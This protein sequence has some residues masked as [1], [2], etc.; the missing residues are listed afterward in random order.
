MRER[1]EAKKLGLKTYSTGKA[2]KHGH[3]AARNTITGKCSECRFPSSLKHREYNARWRSKYP[4]R[5]QE[6]K[7][8]FRYGVELSQIR[9]KP[10]CCEV[11]GSSHKKIV[12]DHCHTTGAFRGWLCDPCN[13]VL[14]LVKDNP[15]TL[16]AL[17]GH[18]RRPQLANVI[19]LLK[20]QNNAISKRQVR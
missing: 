18:L 1:A 7:Y 2:C 10:E 15:E 12:L 19:N 5:D 3:V 6:A 8:R 17:A 20:T 4:G 11:C 16:E 9:A 14:G 13:V